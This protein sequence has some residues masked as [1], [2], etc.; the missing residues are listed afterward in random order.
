MLRSKNV[1]Q[2]NFRD[3]FENSYGTLEYI[4][5]A[6]EFDYIFVENWEKVSESNRNQIK[7]II[8]FIDEVY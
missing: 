2:T 7:R 4:A 3:L 1:F 5:I 6:K 8:L